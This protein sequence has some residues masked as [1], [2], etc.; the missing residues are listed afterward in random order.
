MKH[1]K[2][3]FMAIWSGDCSEYFFQYV[4]D[5]FFFFFEEVNKFCDLDDILRSYSYVWDI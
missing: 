4:K 5:F 2:S 1:V 3:G